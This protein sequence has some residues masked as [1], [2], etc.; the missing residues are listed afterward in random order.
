MKHLFSLLLLCFVVTGCSY[1]APVMPPG[2]LIFSDIAAPLDAD[3]ERQEV[4]GLS[5]GQASSMSI[6]GLVALGDC[7]ITAASANGGL[8]EVEYMDYEY[9]NILLAYQ[10][11]TLKAYGQ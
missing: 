10:K 6:L 5:S 2:G 11:F 8:S 4:S 1:Q 7:S 3:A 9:F